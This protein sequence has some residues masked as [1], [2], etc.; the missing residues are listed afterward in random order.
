[1]AIEWD[2][3]FSVLS[4]SWDLTDS[5]VITDTRNTTAVI[6]GCNTVPLRSQIDTKIWHEELQ[7]LEV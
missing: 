7:M 4:L 3:L 6:F 5:T 2:N 1:M